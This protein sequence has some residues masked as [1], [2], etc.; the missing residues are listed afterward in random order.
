MISYSKSLNVKHTN[1]VRNVDRVYG[2]IDSAAA[3][4]RNRICI[5][6]HRVDKEWKQNLQEFCIQYSSDLPILST[7]TYEVDN[8]ESLWKEKRAET[9]PTNIA[10][11][12]QQTNPVT[13][14]NIFTVLPILAVLPVTTCTC[15]RSVSSLRLIKTYLRSRITQTRL[16]GL[17]SLYTQRN[18]PIYANSVIDR[19]SVKHKRRLALNNILQSDTPPQDN[20][21][22]VQ[23]EMY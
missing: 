23:S 1:S 12:L 19:F 11:T 13:F 5:D 10:D 6:I 7:V 4:N 17:A 22:I 3:K 15:E 9:F 20:D 14:P 21:D 16:N 8:W 2:T 18:I